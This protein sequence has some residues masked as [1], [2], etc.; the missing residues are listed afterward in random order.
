MPR[1]GWRSCRLKSA[2]T[3]PFCSSYAFFASAEAS[4]SPESRVRNQFNKRL[5]SF[6]PYY[7]QPF[8]T[9]GFLRKTYSSLVSKLLTKK[10][11]KQETRVFS[12]IAFCRMEK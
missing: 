8:H 3:R 1:R 4:G 6:V 12:C 5:E 7:S 9:G 11:A 2:T 10:S